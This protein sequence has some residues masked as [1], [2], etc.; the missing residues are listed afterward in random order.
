MK[1]YSPI[2]LA[3]LELGGNPLDKELGMDA[4]SST[5]TACISWTR[6]AES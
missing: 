4:S 5:R 1:N 3:A 6:L 2:K